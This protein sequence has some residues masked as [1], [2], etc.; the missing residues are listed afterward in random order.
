MHYLAILLM[1]RVTLF[2]SSLFSF[3]THRTRSLQQGGKQ[4]A[5]VLYFVTDFPILF[6]YFFQIGTIAVFILPLL[7]LTNDR[8]TVKFMKM[9]MCQ[10]WRNSKYFPLYSVLNVQNLNVGEVSSTWSPY[11]SI[12]PLFELNSSFELTVH[13]SAR[14]THSQKW[15]YHKTNPP[16][17]EGK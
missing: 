3:L 17:H 8:W 5:E 7:C 13:I 14:M 4:R 9:L 12:S 6:E 15:S 1:C 10:K 2:V 11:Y 16:D